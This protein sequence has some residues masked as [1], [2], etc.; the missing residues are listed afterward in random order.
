VEFRI[1]GPS[2]VLDGERRLALPRG[3]GR[4]LLALLSLHASEVVSTERIIDELWGESPPPTVNKA[5]QGLVS[6]LRKRL[7]T[8]RAAGEAP[9]LVRTAP[10][11]YMLDVEPTCVDA[12]QFRRLVAEAGGA[13]ASERSVSLRHALSLWR[14][15]ALADFTYEPFAQR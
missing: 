2:E 13:P 12:H 15:P 14:G 5:L 6:N 11:G 7:G 1:L 8:P 9:A 10:P 3:R 4:A